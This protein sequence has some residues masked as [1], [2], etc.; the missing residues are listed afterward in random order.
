MLLIAKL[1][2]THLQPYSSKPGE[3][4]QMSLST[5]IKNR[6]FDS[7]TNSYVS[8]AVEDEWQDAAD[9]LIRSLIFTGTC[10][11]LYLP[12][13]RFRQSSITYVSVALHAA[14][15]MS[16]PGIT[17]ESGVVILLEASSIPVSYT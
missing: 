15:N 4:E 5:E 6:Y 1:V 13:V 2:A 7:F 14:V 11:T 17:R 3:E 16:L 10:G 12:V 8:S 9:V